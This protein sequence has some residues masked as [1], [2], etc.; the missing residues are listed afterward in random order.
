VDIVI[1]CVT[2]DEATPL[3]WTIKPIVGIAF[4]GF[5]AQIVTTICITCELTLH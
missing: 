2:L 4:G 3:H 1:F 5:G